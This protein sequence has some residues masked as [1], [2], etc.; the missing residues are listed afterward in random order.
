MS[1]DAMQWWLSRRR[2]GSKS[3]MRLSCPLKYNSRNGVT[4]ARGRETLIATP[5]WKE[6]RRA[7][8][9]REFSVK[10]MRGGG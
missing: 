5:L 8:K 1:K 10:R 7:H 2:E 4:E 9:G 3:S 6:W